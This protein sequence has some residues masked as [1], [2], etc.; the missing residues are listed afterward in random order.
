M[1]MEKIWLV[2]RPGDGLPQPPCCSRL[3]GKN[4][5]CQ[6]SVG[7]WNMPNLSQPF[8]ES[9]WLVVEMRCPAGL[10]SL[11]LHSQASF[12]SSVCSSPKVSRIDDALPGPFLPHRTMPSQALAS[13]PVRQTQSTC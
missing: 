8:E 12:E 10:N 3:N 5:G 9:F 2:S 1:D 13:V 4:R 11:L 7:V 6:V